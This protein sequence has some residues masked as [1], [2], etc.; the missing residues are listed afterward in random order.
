M[1]IKASDVKALRD[2]TGAGMMECKHALTEC[3]GDA[4]AAEKLLKEKGLAAVEKR[5]GRATSEGLVLIKN[6]GKKAVMAELTCETDFVAKNVDFITLGNDIIDTA[7]SKGATDVTPELSSK[8]LELATKVRENMSLTR[9]VSLTAGADEY[10]AKYIHSDKKTGVLVMLK[11]DK[12]EA[13]ANPSVQEFAYDCCLHIAAFT[14]LY[15]RTSDVDQAYIAEQTEIFT[16][17][18]EDLDKPA[19]VKAGIV[20]GKIKKHL[21]DICFLEQ[22]FVKDDKL[23]VSK[24][25]EEVGKAAGCKLTLS[26]MVLYQLG[27][28]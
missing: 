26:K 17:Q 27:A 4:A 28:K 1:D 2:K 6:E 7:F 8:V 20:Q 15:S 10:I 12:P 11:S 5:A 23:S 13:F 3:N 18:V 14:P 21:A 9:L 22:A 25:M 16:K 19:N 24:K